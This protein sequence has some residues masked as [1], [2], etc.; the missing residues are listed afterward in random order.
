MRA[1]EELTAARHALECAG[2]LFA[3]ADNHDL[4]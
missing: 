4:G 2:L 1:S 3:T